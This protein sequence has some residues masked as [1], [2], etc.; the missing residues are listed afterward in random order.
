[1]IATD[2]IFDCMRSVCHF[3]TFRLVRTEVHK[4]SKRRSEPGNVGGA[5]LKCPSTN[6]IPQNLWSLPIRE[7]WTTWKFPAIT[8]VVT[9]SEGEPSLLHWQQWL[10]L[11]AWTQKVLFEDG[12]MPLYSIVKVPNSISDYQSITSS[13]HMCTCTCTHYHKLLSFHVYHK[14]KI[15]QGNISWTGMHC[16]AL[17]FVLLAQQWILVSYKK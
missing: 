8:C 10:S 16:L 2:H 7:N 3:T 13:H 9:E 5:V 15:F 14:F 1:M 4:C 17:K 6:I 11:M 12:E